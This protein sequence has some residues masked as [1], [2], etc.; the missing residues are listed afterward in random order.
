MERNKITHGQ[1]G[2]AVSEQRPLNFGK[3]KRDHQA[4]ICLTKEVRI[5]CPRLDSPA[6]KVSPPARLFLT[7]ECHKSTLS[8]T[9]SIPHSSIQTQGRGKFRGTVNF[10]RNVPLP[11]DYYWNTE[12]RMK[13]RLFLWK[14]WKMKLLEEKKRRK[15]GI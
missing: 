5:C 13:S 12:V 7:Q 10:W 4:Q 15:R 1:T 8:H 6:L 11:Q 2:I 3:G 14:G 9:D